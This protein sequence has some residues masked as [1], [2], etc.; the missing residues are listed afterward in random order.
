MAPTITFLTPDQIAARLAD[1]L[2]KSGLDLETLRKR[3]AQFRLS[4]EQT[5]I[6]EQVE[7]L[8]FLARD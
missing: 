3:G 2:E 4:P 8:E 6:L 7:D 1:L 5:V